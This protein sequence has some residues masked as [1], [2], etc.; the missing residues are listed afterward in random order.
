MS[1][2]CSCFEIGVPRKFEELN[3]VP[4]YNKGWEPLP[5]RNMKSFVRR[6]CIERFFSSN[7]NS[8]PYL[9]LEDCCFV[10]EII[11]L[12]SPRKFF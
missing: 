9:M 4:R 7:L 10:F 12:Q 5:Y 6:Y 3:S 11:V 1:R 2:K 8:A